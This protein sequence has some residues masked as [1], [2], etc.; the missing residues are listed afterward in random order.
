MP[1]KVLSEGGTFG[2][3]WE[4]VDQPFHCVQAH[5]VSPSQHCSAL[6][7]MHICSSSY[8]HM[9]VVQAPPNMGLLL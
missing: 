7:C 9:H 1:Q 5:P 8:V 2:I 3:G 4:P 6:A